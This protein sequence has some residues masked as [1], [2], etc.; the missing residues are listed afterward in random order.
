M[1]GLEYWEDYEEYEKHS[2]IYQIANVKT[3]T[4]VL[5]GALDLRVPFTQGQE[6]YTSLKRLGVDTEMIV[7]PR[8]PHGPREPRLLMD[9]SPRI[10]QWF[11][12]YSE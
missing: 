7:Y 8:T 12:K 9:V 4:Q 2:A 5:H 1:G 6:F 11:K 10:L 3:P